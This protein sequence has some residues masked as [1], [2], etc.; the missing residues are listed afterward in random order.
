MD[1]LKDDVMQQS[2]PGK[3]H[4]NTNYSGLPLTCSCR[5]ADLCII[6]LKQRN[7]GC[8][9]RNISKQ[10]KHQKSRKEEFATNLHFSVSGL[11]HQN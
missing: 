4:L 10:K 3:N 8:N 9:K 6:I 5:D 7:N 2:K 1:K 11:L